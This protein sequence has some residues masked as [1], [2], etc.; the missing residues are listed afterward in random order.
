MLLTFIIII[1]IIIIII[2]VLYRA[3]LTKDKEI[4]NSTAALSITGI[5]H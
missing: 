1:I 2:A 3:L 5:E 4:L